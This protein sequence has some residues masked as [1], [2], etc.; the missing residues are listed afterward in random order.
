MARIRGHS[1]T[2]DFT[3]K[4]DETEFNEALESFERMN[5][6]I[7]ARY[8]KNTQARVA[9]REMIPE[10]KRQS[11]SV[12]IT[13]VIGVTTS[14]KRAGELGVKVGVINNDENEFPTFS[15]PALASVL[16]YGTAERY[17]NLKR[18]GFITGRQSTGSMPSAKFLRPAWDMTAPKLMDEVERLVLNRIE[19]SA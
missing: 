5:K 17:R 13:K 7:D 3:I 16:E 11:K 14:K 2:G 12:S 15:A 1:I 6:S 9:R 18:L 19:K 8:L 10:M 4:T